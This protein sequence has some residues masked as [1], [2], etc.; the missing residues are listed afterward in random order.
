MSY[1][2]IITPA[3]LVKNLNKTDW[4]ILDCR[5]QLSGDY[6]DNNSYMHQHIPD[7]YYYSE[8]GRDTVNLM[9]KLYDSSASESEQFISELKEL[10]FNLNTQIII[11]DEQN[12][13]ITNSLWIKLRSLGIPNVAVLQGGFNSWRELNLPTTIVNKPN[14]NERR[15]SPYN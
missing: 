4:L 1:Q 5:S 8:T 6:E 10:G 14:N 2:T 3:T 7:A 11:Y 9:S 13:S 12:S 15:K